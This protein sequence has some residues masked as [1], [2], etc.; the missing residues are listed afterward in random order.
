MKDIH[1][2][3][4]QMVGAVVLGAHPDDAESGCGGL[5]CNLVHMDWEVTI[6]CMT[7]G[8][9]APSTN[10]Q[11][12]NARIRTEEAIKGSE[13]LGTEVGFLGFVD[14]ELVADEEAYRITSTAV[15]DREP[16]LVL[17]HWPADSHTDHQACGILA[18][19]TLIENP[20][21]Q[22]YFYE[23]LTGIQTMNFV[24]THYVDITKNRGNKV[25]ACLAHESQNMDRCV[26]HHKQ[27]GMLRGKE[28]GV[29]YAE[30]YVKAARGPASSILP[31]D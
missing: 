2:F 20:I 12:E 21:F 13:I 6:L 5:I 1:D 22:L 26:A 31:K 15:L 23:V 3:G 17:A 7:R 8:E 9:K 29:K 11:E 18:L 14:G 28:V 19:R 30:A 27:M 10:S 24:P 16:D 25:R 4:D